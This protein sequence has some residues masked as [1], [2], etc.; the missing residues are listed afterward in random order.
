M[1]EAAAENWIFAASGG[2]NEAAKM[3]WEHVSC[4]H[5]NQSRRFKYDCVNEVVYGVKLHPSFLYHYLTDLS[6]VQ[7]NH[8]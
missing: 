2:G 1:A 6:R 5:Y 7:N 3:K 8:M 4:Q